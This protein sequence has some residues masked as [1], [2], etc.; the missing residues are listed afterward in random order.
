[1]TT[2]ITVAADIPASAFFDPYEGKGV[3]VMANLPGVSEKLVYRIKGPRLPHGIV[4][5]AYAIFTCNPDVAGVTNFTAKIRLALPSNAY[6]ADLVNTGVRMD[7]T[8]GILTSATTVIDNSALGTAVAGTA[9]MGTAVGVF[10][11]VSIGSI[12]TGSITAGTVGII[13]IRRLGTDALDTNLGDV[14]LLGAS[15]LC[16]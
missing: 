1:M 7:A 14:I 3:G 2:G 9:T 6:N 12:S 11:A 15:L 4:S 10:S 16:A 5:S 13:R 8:L